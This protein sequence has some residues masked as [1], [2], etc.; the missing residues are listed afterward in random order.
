LP[1]AEVSGRGR[2]VRVTEAARVFEAR[3]GIALD[4]VSSPDAFRLMALMHAVRAG[5]EAVSTPADGQRKRGRPA[6][7]ASLVAPLRELYDWLGPAN[8]ALVL[9]IFKHHSH[10]A[11]VSAH[12]SAKGVGYDVGSVLRRLERRLGQIARAA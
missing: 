6:L 7:P 5:L 1:I 11:F 4:G 10:D 12:A 3:T 2:D 9:M 8:G